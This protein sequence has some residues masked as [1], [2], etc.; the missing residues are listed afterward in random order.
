MTDSEREAVARA[1]KA[2]KVFRPTPEDLADAAIAALDAHRAGQVCVWRLVPGS[3]SMYQTCRA[4]FSGKPEDVCD[5]CGKRVEM[6][7]G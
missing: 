5:D 4:I 6:K 3:R 2:I 7:N 1:I